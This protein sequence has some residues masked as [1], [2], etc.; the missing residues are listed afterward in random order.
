MRHLP[1]PGDRKD[2]LPAAL[3]PD[4]LLLPCLF[5]FWTEDMAT[6]RTHYY[7]SVAFLLFIFTEEEGTASHNSLLYSFQLTRQTLQPCN[8]PDGSF[9]THFTSHAVKPGPTSNTWAIMNS[10]YPSQH[11][12]TCLSACEEFPGLWVDVSRAHDVSLPPSPLP[13]GAFAQ[14]MDMALLPS[15]PPALPPTYFRRSVAACLVMASSPFLLPFS[16][17]VNGGCLMAFI[18]LFSLHSML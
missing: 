14:H 4:V 1:P 12:Q 5:H 2:G 10:C 9:G 18:S 15:M 11:S 3:L 8:L 7:T 17:E 13:Y 16:L 6:A